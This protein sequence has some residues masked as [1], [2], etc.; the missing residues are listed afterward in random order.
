MF[1]FYPFISLTICSFICLP[2]IIFIL[3]LYEKH[4]KTNTNFSLTLSS[5]ILHHFH[6]FP[7]NS[8]FYTNFCKIKLTLFLTLLSYN[9]TNTKK[10]ITYH[11]FHDKAILLTHNL[12]LFLFFIRKGTHNFL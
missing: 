10:S 12:V 2:Y 8:I 5:Y 7:I 3:S 9:Y 6:S 1:L 4:F 11:L